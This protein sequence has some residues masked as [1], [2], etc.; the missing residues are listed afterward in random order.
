MN[1]PLPATAQAVCLA[2]V[3]EESPARLSAEVACIDQLPKHRSRPVF[4][5]SEISVQHLND[6]K[7]HIQ[8]D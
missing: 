8:T 7:H 1:T 6:E 3:F 2:F 5:V 4:I